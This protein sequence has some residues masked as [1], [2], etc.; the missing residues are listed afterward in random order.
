MADVQ[1]A[2]APGASRRPEDRAFDYVALDQGGRRVRGSLRA[3]S[4]LVAFDQLK[5][6]GLSPLRLQPGRS[7]AA[8]V[9]GGRGISDRDAADLLGDLAV[10]L[11]AGSDLRGA[12]A[13]A[14]SKSGRPGVIRVCQALQKDV[15]GG[16]KL[17]DAFA[18]AL[19]P[20]LAFA[21]AL[22]AAGE[23]SGDLA[24]ALERAGALISTQIRIREQLVSALSYPA[25]VFLTFIAAVAIL[26][27]FVIPSL[28]PLFDQ[29][30]SK[31]P[32]IV[33]AMIWASTLLRAHA[34]ALAV[35]GAA[36]AIAFAI[37]AR[38]GILGR[39]MD[40]LV[41]DG[42]FRRT[43]RGFTYGAFALALG[44]M[45]GGGASLPEALGLAIR[46]ARS[47]TARRR[48]T[49]V[50]D[51]V[52]QGRRLSDCLDQIPGLP[53]TVARL[54]AIGESSGKLG[55][56]LVRA[57]ELEERAALARIARLANLAGPMLIVGLGGLIGLL[58]GGLLSGIAQIGTAALN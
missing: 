4:D 21:P 43:A 5:R 56:M 41:Q 47:P 28:A 46:S 22:V 52:R 12:F 42:P 6:Q 57:G 44:N 33:A 25:F 45:L 26:L 17:E 37:L 48:L 55:P 24:G 34:A 32:P 40:R 27:L 29:M 9:A 35:G 50:V 1:S 8:R 49:P 7:G 15:S 10:L 23:A 30:G 39:A 58:M 11:E 54:S 51:A 2:A 36:L 53:Q 16:A 19:G 38:V 14:G 31:P 13:I 20:R 3:S 18:R